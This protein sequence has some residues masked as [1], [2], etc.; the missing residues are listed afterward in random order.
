MQSGIWRRI[1]GKIGNPI[2]FQI[3]KVKKIGCFWIIVRWNFLKFETFG[4][5]LTWLETTTRTT[6]CSLAANST[7]G[8][9]VRLQSKFPDKFRIQKRS[10]GLMC[11]SSIKLSCAACLLKRNLCPCGI[12]LSCAACLLKRNLCPCGINDKSDFCLVFSFTCSS[13]GMRVGWMGRISVIQNSRFEPKVIAPRS[14]RT[15][16]EIRKPW[17]RNEG[18][19][20]W[21]RSYQ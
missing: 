4:L 13:V 8:G 15:Q 6:T 10:Q 2:G 7:V 9:T 11:G 16:R 18:F 20:K 12:K 5:D 3:L 14:L 19:L 21:R 17:I 1:C